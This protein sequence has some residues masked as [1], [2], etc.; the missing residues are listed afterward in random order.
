MHGTIAATIRRVRILRLLP[1]LLLLIPAPAHGWGYKGHQLVSEAAT[2]HVPVGMPA[3]FHRAYP[4]LVYLGYE[5]D[6]WRS[7]GPSLDNAGPPEHFLD[8]E[9]V[10]H[11]ELPAGRFEALDL[12]IASGTLR[13]FGLETDTAG[14]LP[15]RIAELTDLLE[16]Q[17]RL[18][19]R[20]EDVLEREQIEQNIIHAA[21]ILGHYVAD[22]ANPHH[23][24]IHY[25]GWVGDPGPGFRFDCEAHRRF[26]SDFVSRR[27]GLADVLPVVQ[28]LQLREDHF[29]SAMDFV[30]DS[31]SLVVTLYAIDRDGGFD[32]KGT[33]RGLAFAAGRIAQASSWLRDLWWSAYVQGTSSSAEGR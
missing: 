13:R 32:G 8:Y 25:N 7:G 21:G 33:A 17:W 16:L 9:Y 22:A 11:L 18:W 20:T 28:P 26:E 27:V 24:T 30:K 31:N 14:F 1:F 12:M 3:F 6:R 2:F 4:S 15:W 23:S 5:P 10:S 29:A 19:S